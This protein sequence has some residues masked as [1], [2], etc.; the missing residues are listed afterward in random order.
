MAPVESSSLTVSCCFTS[1]GGA[2]K[3]NILVAADTYSC[4]GYSQNCNVLGLTDKGHFLMDTLASKGAFQM[5]QDG[6][7]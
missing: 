1:S 5:T 6:N 4:P 3:Y 2:G 7:V